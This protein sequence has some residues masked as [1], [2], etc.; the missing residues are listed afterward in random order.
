[1][2]KEIK[3]GNAA[4]EATSIL[5]RIAQRI[6]I[7]YVWVSGPGKTEQERIRQELA[8]AHT[9]EMELESTSIVG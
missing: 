7:G 6:I 8:K 1:M 5:E 4:P 3:S 2:M 9:V